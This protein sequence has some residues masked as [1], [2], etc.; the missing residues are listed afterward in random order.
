MGLPGHLKT[1]LRGEQLAARYL[2]NAGYT[3]IAANFSNPFGETD[4]IARAPDGTVCFTE[5]K[6]RSDGAALPPS[7][8]VDAGK[9]KRLENSA[10]AYFR[11]T[12]TPQT[13]FRF[14]IIEIYLHG[15]DCAD[16]N[17]IENAF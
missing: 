10:A 5:V 1:G 7:E 6:T 12:N 13:P 16:I 8:A 3:V 17:H 14:D 2:K 4:L 15:L 9:R 11:Y